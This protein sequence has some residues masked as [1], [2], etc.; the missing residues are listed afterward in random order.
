MAPALQPYVLAGKGF[1]TKAAVTDHGRLV[2]AGMADGDT[3]TD[4]VLLALLQTHPE[5]EE[6]AAD[7]VRIVAGT[8]TTYSGTPSKAFLI[9]TSTGR[10]IDI[11]WAKLVRFLERGGGITPRD[12]VMNHLDK[13]RSAARAAIQSQVAALFAGPGQHVDHAPP[14]TFEVLLHAF[15]REQ[16]VRVRQIEVVD[17]AG[18]RVHRR[19]SDPQLDQNWQEFHRQR[20]ELRILTAMDHARVQKIRVDWTALL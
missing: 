14:H 2:R 1:A 18:T 17:P 5:W 4:P 8:V 12:E 16:G 20:A 3:L 10:L 19:W 15:F 9:E 13:V 11:S 6:K 7:L